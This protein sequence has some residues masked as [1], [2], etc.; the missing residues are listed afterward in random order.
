[1]SLYQCV[2]AAYHSWKVLGR[3]YR[4]LWKSGNLWAVPILGFLHRRPGFNQARWKV[5][6]G[7]ATHPGKCFPEPQRTPG[8]RADLGHLIPAALAPPLDATVPVG[9]GE[10]NQ[11]QR[12]VAFGIVHRRKAVK[13]LDVEATLKGGCMQRTT[14]Q[15]ALLTEQTEIQMNPPDIRYEY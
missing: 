8:I 5:G 1:L 9:D 13:D 2:V 10:V 11:K 15:K 7:Y 6:S 14:D 4:G 12:G 3:T